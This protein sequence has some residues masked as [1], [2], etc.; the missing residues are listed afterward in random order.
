MSTDFSGIASSL[1]SAGYG[2]DAASVLATCQTLLDVQE[3]ASQ[4][5]FRDFRD[6]V[7]W[8]PKIFSKL[9]TIGKDERLFDYATDLPASYTA[10]YALA[11]LSDEEFAAAGEEGVI[12]TSSSVRFIN[13]WV[14]ARRLHGNAVVEE[15]ALTLTVRRSKTAEEV[16]ALLAI[17][18]GAA[19][20]AGASL[21]VGAGSVREAVAG[22]RQATAEQ[23][24]ALLVARMDTVVRSADP[25]LLEQFSVSSGE[26]LAKGEM[27][28]FTGFLVRSTGSTDAMWEH[29]GKDYCLKV[30][31][32]FNSTT[33]RAQRFNYKK[34]L[35]EVKEKHPELGG[36]VDQCLEEWCK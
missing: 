3:Q 31:L 21:R 19:D 7:G 8:H 36:T 6:A 24:L 4:Q 27:R 33:S 34:R 5:E 10:I 9:L 17:L 2:D 32:E 13:D 16:D 26:G 14:K 22:E 18:K 12:S 23:V 11:S 30:C 35:L 28:Q 29:H 25:A 15:I 20:A 1:A